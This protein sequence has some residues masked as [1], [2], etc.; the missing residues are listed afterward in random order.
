MLRL[1]EHL[2][3]AG[4]IHRLARPEEAFALAQPPDQIAADR[5]LDVGY[6]MV[7]TTPGPRLPLVDQLREAQRA[8]AARST[9]ASLQ[10]LRPAGD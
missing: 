5:L 3:Q 2:E 9:L 8:V 7:E 1:L 10:A 4:F 6:Q